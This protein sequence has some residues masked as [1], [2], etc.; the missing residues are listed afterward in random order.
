M[1]LKINEKQLK[2]LIKSV[3]METVYPDAK[4]LNDYDDNF[5]VSYQINPGSEPSNYEAFY[6]G[7]PGSDEEEQRELDRLDSMGNLDAFERRGLESGRYYNSLDKYNDRMQDKWGDVD[8]DTKYRQMRDDAWKLERD[9]WKG[10]TDPQ[11]QEDYNWNVH[12]SAF[13]GGHEDMRLKAFDDSKTGDKVRRYNGTVRSIHENRN[14]KKIVVNESVLNNMIRKTI[15][16]ALSE[17]S[18]ERKG[19][20]IVKANNKAQDLQNAYDS[21]QRTMKKGNRTVDVEDE[22]RR[23]NRQ[24]DTF[25]DGLSHDIFMKYGKDRDDISN[26]IENCSS[27]IMKLKERLSSGKCSETEQVRIKNEIS[28]TVESLKSLYAYTG[29]FSVYADKDGYKISFGDSRRNNNGVAYSHAT[30]RGMHYSNPKD[31]NRTAQMQD[32]TDILMGADAELTGNAKHNEYMDSLQTDRDNVAGSRA[33]DQ[34]R[35]DWSERKRDQERKQYEYDSQPFY[36]KMFSKRPEDFSEP[37][38]EKYK[39][40]GNGYYVGDNKPEDY[41]RWMNDQRNMNNTYI[42]AYKNYGKK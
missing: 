2:S 26:R 24:K 35:K 14:R 37:E 42:N 12:D 1:N 20:G 36:K 33:S 13:G 8:D 32:I 41:D 21:G 9:S 25:S 23:K 34:A 3:I 5:G 18:P 22:I 29:G 30:Q 6:T 16:E 19:M 11:D 15:V 10:D 27:R 7:K 17:V 31:T 28:N 38:P 4:A 40:K 39:W